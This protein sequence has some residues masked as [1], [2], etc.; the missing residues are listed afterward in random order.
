MASTILLR[1]QFDEALKIL[2]LG[3]EAHT[4]VE[5]RAAFLRAIRSTHPDLHQRTS[6]TEEST[7]VVQAYAVLNS[8][9]AEPPI[10]PAVETPPDP[11]RPTFDPHPS[12][13]IALIADDT[14]EVGAPTDEVFGLLLEVGHRCGEI[15]FLDRSGA[16]MQI[17]VGFVDQPICQLIVDLQGRAAR[18]TTE[19]FCTIE[20]LD[21]REPPDI[22]LVARFLAEQM[23]E[24]V[25]ISHPPQRPEK[26]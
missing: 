2:G 13:D 14:I 7:R 10:E 20:S 26:G 9:I 23:G 4:D 3:P 12:V 18:G 21:D 16:V 17:L 5:V 22:E 6:A 11:Q 24:L 1:V 19:I 15:T 25:T 8:A